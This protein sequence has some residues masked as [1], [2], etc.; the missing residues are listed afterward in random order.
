MKFNELGG[1]YYPDFWKWM[2][3]EI[4][5]GKAWKLGVKGNSVGLVSGVVRVW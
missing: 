2:L 5:L 1:V 3:R 4:F